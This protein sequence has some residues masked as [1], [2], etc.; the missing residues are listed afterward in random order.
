MI[1]ALRTAV[2]K[3]IEALV[4]L[5]GIAFALSGATAAAVFGKALLAA[6]LGALALGFFLRFSGR[7]AASKT[8]VE[9]T[10]A[11]VSAVSGLLSLVEVGVLVEATNLPVRYTQDGFELFHWALVLLAFGIAFIAQARAI[12]RIAYRGHGK[13]V[14]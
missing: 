4:D 10:P 7:R 3:R 8:S 11:W 14:L 13:H 9:S 1:A 5:G 12:R 2:A 6:V